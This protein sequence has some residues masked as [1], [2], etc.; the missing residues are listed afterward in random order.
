MLKRFLGYA[1]LPLTLA[2]CT[3]AG[4]DAVASTRAPE[5][6]GVVSAADP[7]AAEAGVEM[8]RRGGSATDAALATMI[9]LTVV[10]PQSSG[11]GGGGFLLWGGADGSIETLDGR[12]AAPMAAGPGWFLGDDGKPRPFMQAVLSGLSVGVPGNVRLAAEAHKA[13]GKLEWAE[14]FGP[15]I[16][17]ARDGFVL[18]ERGRDFFTL[19]RNR[20]AATPAGLALFYDAAGEPLPAGTVI[21]NPALAA[22]LERL[23]KDGPD[24]F[25]SGDNAQAIVTAVSAA[26]PGARTMVSGDLEHYAA[27]F[28]EPVCGSYRRWKICGMGPPSSGATTVIAILKQLEGFDLTAL[29]KDSPVAW[30]LFAESQ[31]LAFADRELYLADEDFVQV[32]VKGLID[33]TYLHERGSLISPTSTMASVTAG[34]PWPG[35]ASPIARADGDEPPENG[36]SHFVAVDRWGNAVSYTSTVEGSFGSGLMVGG[37]YLNNELTDFSFSPEAD[38][39]PVANRVEPGKRPRSSMAP[40]LV[41]DSDGRLV[42]AIG[43]AGGA[44]IPVQVAK[45]LIGYLDWGL[46]AQDAIA[47]PVLYSPGDTITVEEGSALAAMVPALEALGHT[48]VAPRRLPLKANAVEWR[49]G[50]WIGAADPRSEGV[51]VTQ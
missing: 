35:D 6:P 17:L 37:Y 34:S 41:Y 38:G 13:H 40:T 28:R 14:L 36:T 29:G 43:A 11:I 15:A 18:T 1:L 24:A 3:A 7:R 26:T 51:A 5:A 48:G 27:R 42:L 39:V 12:E 23:A 30:H 9:A 16:K 31:R 8:L 33:D 46:T 21:K 19:A 20:A 45:A 47:L 2:A 50:H 44:T 10:E 22:T 32:P 25:Y 49:D 4:G